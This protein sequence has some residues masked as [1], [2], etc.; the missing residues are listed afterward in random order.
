MNQRRTTHQGAMF[1]GDHKCWGRNPAFDVQPPRETLR[2]CRFARTERPVQNH[3]VA[4]FQG[5]AQLR[6]KSLGVSS[7][8][9]PPLPA[10]RKISFHGHPLP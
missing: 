10:S 4:C 7:R 5:T 8:F 9:K 6:T 3:H 2:E 1:T